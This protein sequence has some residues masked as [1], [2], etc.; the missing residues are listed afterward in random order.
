MLL[1]A[2]KLLSATI[3]TAN[4]A[5]ETYKFPLGNLIKDKKFDQEYIEV[6]K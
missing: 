5:K 1:P 2:N 3:C 4:R 6:L